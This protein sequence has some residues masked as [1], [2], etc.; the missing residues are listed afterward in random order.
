MLIRINSPGGTVGGSEALYKGLRAIAEDRP[1]ASYISTIGASGGYMAAMAADKIYSQQTSIV[2]SIG[3]IMRIPEFSEAF[4]HIGVS[5]QDVKSD[6]LKGGPRIDSPLTDDQRAELQQ[7]VD[8]TYG[9]FLNLVIDRRNMEAEE[10]R[11][12]ADGRVYSGQRSLELGLVDELATEKDA[13]AWLREQE[14]VGVTL[15][16]ID[17]RKPEFDN[18]FSQAMA[19]IG[20]EDALSSTLALDGLLALWQPN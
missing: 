8:D 6:D 14:G 20:L 13:I 15:P 17:V 11:L 12:V 4:D 5:I 2:G 9:W 18:I 7:L 3:V 10:A 1:A 19:W 16:V